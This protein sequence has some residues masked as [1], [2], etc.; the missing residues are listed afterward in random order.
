MKSVPEI[1]LDFT[2]NSG[3]VFL[4]EKID[5][6]WYGVNGSNILQVTERPFKLRS[7][8][9]NHD[10]FFRQ[11]DNLIKILKEIS[12]D[13]VV[14]SAIKQ[15]PGL[16]LLRQDPF[17]CYISFICS[18]NSSIQNIRQMLKKICEKFGKKTNFDG[19]LFSTFPDAKKLANASMKDLLSCGLGFRA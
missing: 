2:I 3:Q 10:S 6:Q 17:Q 5:E 9:N 15:F 18:S 11:D 19:H 1:N 13:G 12:K 16:R 14:R 8:Q 4:W 7:L